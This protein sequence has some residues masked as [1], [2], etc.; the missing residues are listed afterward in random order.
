MTAKR[1]GLAVLGG[2]R[3]FAPA[4]TASKRR[5]DAR[6]HTAPWR[7]TSKAVLLRDRYVF[8]IVAGCLT[9]ARVVDHIDP[10]FPAMS[11][12]A[13]FDRGNLRAGCSPHNVARGIELAEARRRGRSK[14]AAS[15][16]WA[17]ALPPRI[18]GDYS[19]KRAGQGAAE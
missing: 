19:R 6:Y 8:Q 11:D 4:P 15:S 17:T 12:A 3:L 18:T 10:T 13:F 16:R 9:A 5:S 2:N 7:R 14:P 1:R